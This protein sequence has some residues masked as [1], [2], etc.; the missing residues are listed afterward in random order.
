MLTVSRRW[1]FPR[2]IGEEAMQLAPIEVRHAGTGIEALRQLKIFA[3]LADS[4]LDLIAGIRT[5][6]DMTRVRN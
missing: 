2:P 6:G 3:E 4:Q 5:S 1:P